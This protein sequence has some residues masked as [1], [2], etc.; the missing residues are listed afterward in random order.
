MTRSAFSVGLLMTAAIGLLADNAF[1]Q[2]PAA[3]PDIDRE[4]VAITFAQTHHPELAALLKRLKSTDK[5]AYRK[6][7]RDVF[8]TSERLVRLERNDPERY[9]RALRL[10]TLD[11]RIRLLAARSTMSSDPEI[12]DRLRKLL[13][14]RRQ[15]RLAMLQWER[16]R[17]EARL[18]R[19]D[20][21]IDRLKDDGDQAVNGELNRLKRAV[22]AKRSRKESADR[23]RRDP[24]RDASPE[25]SSPTR[26]RRET[27]NDGDR[28]RTA[29]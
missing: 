13:R 9:D 12:D 21:Q 14:E 5:A 6:A 17:L 26:T 19:I 25:E 29:K 22:R 2:R 24:A 11:S 3:D 18:E 27:P 20:D 10:W 15:V 4:Q 7:I 1:A 8:Q 16:E 23:D 28:N